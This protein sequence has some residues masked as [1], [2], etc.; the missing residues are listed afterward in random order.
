[1]F[2]KRLDASVISGK[3]YTDEACKELHSVITKLMD[4]QKEDARQAKEGLLETADQVQ[5]KFEGSFFFFFF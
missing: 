2:L 5:T 3:V 1:M 4:K